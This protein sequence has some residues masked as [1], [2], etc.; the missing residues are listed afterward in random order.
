MNVRHQERCVLGNEDPE[1]VWG[2]EVTECVKRRA[3]EER[4]VRKWRI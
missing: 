3:E 4:R 2:A 1:Q